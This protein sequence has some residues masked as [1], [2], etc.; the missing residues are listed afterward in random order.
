[1]TDNVAKSAGDG[2]A[3][4]PS[5]G[6]EL[7]CSLTKLSQALPAG[8]LLP[9]LQEHLVLV[10]RGQDDMGIQEQVAATHLFGS[11]DI[12]WDT[13]HHHPDDSRVQIIKNANRK[14]ITYKSS[15]LYWH[16]DQSFT[17][18]PSP[19]TM[20]RAITLPKSGGNTLFADTRSAYD[21]L[22]ESLRGIARSVNVMHSFSHLMGPLIAKRQ[23]PDKAKVMVQRFPDVIHP[24]V[25]THSFTQRH[26][27]FL[28]ELCTKRIEGCPEAVSAALLA[29]YYEHTLKP[30][31]IY[32]HEWRLGDVV[33]WFNP[34][35][36]HRA[37]DIPDEEP[38]IL[39]RTNTR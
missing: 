8:T 31:G 23:G 39:Y 34:G 1:M 9:L 12:P 3:L 20:L 5:F 14:G 4:H 16:S 21:T 6:L 29:A 17:N 37:Q 19:V 13:N 30:A 10:F 36:L 24:L 38:R 27:L 28:N 15:T 7:E 25:V 26:A 22:T 2:F 35:L 32:T 18:H 33:V 11:V